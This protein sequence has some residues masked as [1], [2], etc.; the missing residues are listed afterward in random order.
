MV[1]TRKLCEAHDQHKQQNRYRISL[2]FA[3]E[4]C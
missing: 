4:H 3:D 2:I 1:K